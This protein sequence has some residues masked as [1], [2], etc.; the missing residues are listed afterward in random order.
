MPSAHR[1]VLAGRSVGAL[2]DATLDGGRL[3][4]AYYAL[5]LGDAANARRLLAGA[6]GLPEALVDEALG[7]DVADESEVG[8]RAARFLARALASGLVEAA[9]PAAV[10]GFKAL[11]LPFCAHIAALR[12]FD[13]RPAAFE[14]L[15]GLC[16]ARNAQRP[17]A[18]TTFERFRVGK[19]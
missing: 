9:S 4:A 13:A 3:P 6:H 8:A 18:V 12:Y 15:R 11:L 17:A 5:E 19:R 14:A 16:A 1:A 10:A 7:D 2:G